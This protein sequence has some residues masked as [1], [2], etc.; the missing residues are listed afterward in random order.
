MS[1]LPEEGVAR[2]EATSSNL[3]RGDLGPLTAPPDSVV[4]R[5]GQG[6]FPKV[7]GPTFSVIPPSGRPLTTLETHPSGFLTF[8]T[9]SC[10]SCPRRARL[11]GL[12]ASSLPQSCGQAQLHLAKL[13][14]A[15]GLPSSSGKGL[16]RRQDSDELA[17]PGAEGSHGTGMGQGTQP[18]TVRTGD[19][20]PF[21]SLLGGLRR[22]PMGAGTE[23]A[24]GKNQCTGD[25]PSNSPNATI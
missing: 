9:G 20:A 14:V 3:V 21:P 18:V 11:K 24:Q 19:R 4:G 23:A 12:E 25:S 15:E 2:V 1:P 6:P 5:A 13:R 10:I 7:P 17:L 16:G 8:D 22:L